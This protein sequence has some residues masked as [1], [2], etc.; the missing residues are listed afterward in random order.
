MLMELKASE[1]TEIYT[2]HSERVA[3]G[4]KG[5]DTSFLFVDSFAFDFD[6]LLGFYLA[7]IR[8]SALSK[9]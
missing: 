2:S 3:A 4:L 1:S 7:A 5:S 8:G 9:N 6:C